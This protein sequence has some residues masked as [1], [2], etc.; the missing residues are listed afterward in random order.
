MS[1][2]HLLT[3]HDLSA[4][5]IQEIL[6]RAKEIK[7]KFFKKKTYIPLQ[8]KTLGLYF[9]KLSTRTR[10]SFEVGM[11]QL[12]GHS[13]LISPE[14]IQLSRGETIEDTARV[15][16]RY[17]NGIV[18]RTYS[19]RKLEEW[20][21]FSSIPIINGLTDLH[22]PCQA[23]SDL[24]TILEKRGH[25]QK[26]N[27][28]YIGD[29]NNVAHSLIEGAVL[30][31]MNVSL[32]CPR[33]YEPNEGIIERA[34]REAKRNHCQVQIFDNPNDA[35]KN[36]DI[37]YTDVWTCMGQETEQEDRKKV[38]Q[39]YC[40]DQNLMDATQNKETLV[41]HCLPAHRGEEITAEVM[42]GPSSIIFDQAE[43]RL[44][45]HKA[46]LDFLLKDSKD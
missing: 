17:L 26:L 7:Q 41:M 3:L 15:L 32:A 35:V 24:F 46:I 10:I 39:G 1:I 42:E 5:D 21:R 30:M 45:T 28:A 38:F 27:L 22:H 43:N 8:G 34:R 19:Q 13:L 9:E 18:I 44:H 37:L 40:I 4:Q 36:A 29:G 23:L 33:G 31:G 16:S 2:R 25:I 6:D 20:A 14:E 11:Y 12:G